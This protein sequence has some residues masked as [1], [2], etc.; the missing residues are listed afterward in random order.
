MLGSD[1]VRVRFDNSEKTLDLDASPSVVLPAEMPAFAA[2]ADEPEPAW[3]SLLLL[4][5]SAC[6][7]AQVVAQ[8]AG[9][10]VSLGSRY[11]LRLARAGQAGG[12]E[13][14]VDL[15]RYN[16]SVLRDFKTVAEYEAARSSYCVFQMHE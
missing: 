12:E 1:V 3:P 6:V 16:H 11:T 9:P 4:H 10:G 8:V 7:D 5:G 2:V 15:N 14:Q 13:V